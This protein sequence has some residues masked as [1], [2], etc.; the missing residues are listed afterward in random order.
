MPTFL[1][2]VSAG[3]VEVNIAKLLC[4]RQ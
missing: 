1:K 4:T 2:E 3:M